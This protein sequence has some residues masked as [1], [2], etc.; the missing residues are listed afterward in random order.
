[1]PTLQEAQARYQSVQ[2]ALVAL[3]ATLATDEQRSA[4]RELHREL[5]AA[6]KDAAGALDTGVTTLSGGHDKDADQPQP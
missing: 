5:W 3:K 1:M 6:A 4:A 2:A